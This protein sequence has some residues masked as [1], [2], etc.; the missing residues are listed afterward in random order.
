MVGWH[1]GKLKKKEYA[2]IQSRIMGKL[3]FEA[4]W[5]KHEIFACM[6]DGKPRW[7]LFGHSIDFNPTNF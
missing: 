6:I 5:C 4:R 2:S 7:K 3:E 1:G